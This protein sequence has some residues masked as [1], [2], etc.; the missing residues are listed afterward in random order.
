[1][2][3]NWDSLAGSKKFW[4][5]LAG[6]ENVEL[7]CVT[8]ESFAVV[9]CLQFGAAQVLSAVP[10]LCCHRWFGEALG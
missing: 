4:D 8:D 7:D 3:S 6:K 5:D 2:C 10:G 1:M 9:Q